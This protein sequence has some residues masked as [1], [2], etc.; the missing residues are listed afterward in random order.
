MKLHAKVIAL[1]ATLGALFTSAHA[2]ITLSFQAQE[3][4]QGGVGS[5]PAAAGSL[6]LLVADTTGAGFDA[7]DSGPITV[8][9]LIDQAG[10]DL[11][12][13]QFSLSAA[14]IFTQNE[15]TLNASQAFTLS[16]NWTAG[17]PLAIYWIPTLTTAS[18]TVGSGV[19]YGEYTDITGLNGSAAWIT[20]SNGSTYGPMLFSTSGVFGTGNVAASTGY[21]SH[22]TSSQVTVPEPALGALL[23]GGLGLLAAAITR[24][25]KAAGIV[26]S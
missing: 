10:N 23:A 14:S 17:D 13:G 26:G 7:L 21:A 6:V 4:L 22:F 16:G 19:A 5:N 9:S 12:V 15:P 2:T 25:R 8:G 1:A 11:V 24:R 18:T 3:L 20:P